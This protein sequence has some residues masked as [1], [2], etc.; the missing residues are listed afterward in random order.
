MV[1]SL[2]LSLHL[3]VYYRNIKPPVEFGESKH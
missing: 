1:E 2:I 3:Q